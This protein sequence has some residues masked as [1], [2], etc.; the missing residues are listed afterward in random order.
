MN[1]QKN[2]NLRCFNTMESQVHPSSIVDSTAIL[3]KNCKVGPYAIIEEGVI[4]GENCEI[5]AHA[6][7]KKD[8]VLENN[9]KVGHF[10][11]IGGDPQ[12][13][14]FDPSVKSNVH[15]CAEVRIGEGVTIHRSIYPNGVT[16]IGSRSFLMGYSHVAHDG[17]LGNEVIMAN[18]ALLGGHVTIGDFT[19]IGGGAGVHQFAR[20]GE[21]VMIG[22]LAEVSKDVPPFI[23]ISGRNQACGLNLVGMK[24]RGISN[25]ES[26]V[27]KL[28]YRS[29]LMKVGNPSVHAQKFL[30]ENKVSSNS[31]AI[32]FAEF[33]LTENRGFVKSKSSIH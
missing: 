15:I 6:I 4:L 2:L 32:N 1:L 27:L 10:A 24:R 25:D 33:F 31:K 7:I 8:T 26:K 9:V 18:G 14:T 3:Q 11:V 16:K 19:F 30:D 5:D 20:I 17:D 12:H 13:L 23:T 29:I 22:G 21:G 28:A